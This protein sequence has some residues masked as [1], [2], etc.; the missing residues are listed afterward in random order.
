[1]FAN[2]KFRLMRKWLRSDQ[3]LVFRPLC[4]EYLDRALAQ[5][6]DDFASN[7]EAL[8]L[9]TAGR[10]LSSGAVFDVGAHQGEW[11]RLALASNPAWNVHCFEPNPPTFAVLSRALE[12]HAGRVRLH[13]LALSDEPG[14]TPLYNFAG[15]PGMS[16][17]HQ[18]TSLRSK[19]GF[20]A[21][22]GA[23]VRLETLD[24]FCA[25]H[26]ISHLSLLKIDAEGHEPK[27]LAGARAQLAQ[28]SIEAVQFEYG[29]C[30]IDARVFLIDVW[31]FLAECGYQL[32]KVTPNG[33]RPYPEYEPELEN[34]QY[35]NFVALAPGIRWPV[36][37]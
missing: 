28:G 1:M 15:L 31:H 36:S 13:P 37:T 32:N 17:L 29:G 16:T 10:V 24:R 4:R 9:R 34:F 26:G 12:A 27:I 35:G 20:A 11:T 33:L 25:H 19:P 2:L 18:R 14:A 21:A 6:N 23:P 8:F 5:N 7:G 30:W 22:Q 3:R